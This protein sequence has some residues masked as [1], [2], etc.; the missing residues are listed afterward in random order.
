MTTEELTL[1]GPFLRKAASKKRKKPLN[2]SLLL[3]G[4]SHSS[5]PGILTCGEMEKVQCINGRSE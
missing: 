1:K 2:I 3:V 4:L 5:S